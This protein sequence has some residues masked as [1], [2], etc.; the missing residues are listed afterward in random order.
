MINKGIKKILI[1][2]CMLIIFTL[3]MNLSITGLVFHEI[4][5]LGIGIIF[6]LHIMLNKSWIK[7]IGSNLRNKNLKNKYKIMFYLNLIT[8]FSVLVLIISGVLISRYVLTTITINN[9]SIVTTIHK[10]SANL[11]LGLIC[12]HLGIH[13]D[14]L[15]NS[16]KNLISF[17]K[18]Q[19]KKKLILKLTL[20]VAILVA[21]Y[22]PIYKYVSSNYDNSNRAFYGYE[23]NKGNRD[24]KSIFGDDDSNNNDMYPQPP[25]MNNNGNMP[26]G[27]QSGEFGGFQ[28]NS[29]YSQENGTPS[30]GENINTNQEEDN[31][32]INDDNNDSSDSGLSDYLSKLTCTGCGRQCLL[33]NPKCNKGARQAEEATEEYNNSLNS[34]SITNGEV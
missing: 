24:L 28:G 21:V 10:L 5:G 17:I 15:I 25:D 14:Y 2:I 32:S 18:E 7:S 9:F 1:D 16:F 20:N 31:E 13:L 34:S 12:I 4:F 3:L 8:F 33:S 22:I 26:Q 29:E 6:I 23:N 27:G 30:T 11:S 19:N